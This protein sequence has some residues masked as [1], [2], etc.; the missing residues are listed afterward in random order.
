MP[1]RPPPRWLRH[2]RPCTSSPEWRSRCSFKRVCGCCLQAFEKLAQYKQLLKLFTT[3]E[4]FHF[5]ELKAGLAAELATPQL[6]PFTKEEQQKII[7]VMQTRVTQVGA[8]SPRDCDEIAAR[9][10]RDVR[11]SPRRG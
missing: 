5:S 1:L 4:I 11:R 6:G 3:K 9:S 10:R 2:P 8:R 7:E